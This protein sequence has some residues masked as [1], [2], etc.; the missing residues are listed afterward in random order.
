MPKIAAK[1]A[2]HTN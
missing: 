1:T 2:V